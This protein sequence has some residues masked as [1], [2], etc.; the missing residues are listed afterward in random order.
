MSK[1]IDYQLK[2]VEDD[3]V[4][5]NNSKV[6]S[7]AAFK[8]ARSSYI[9]MGHKALAEMTVYKDKERDALQAEIAELREQLE[10]ARID[11]KNLKAE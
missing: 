9:G 1:Q 5:A 2:A 10:E 3:A 11:N 6:L 4:A 7:A 8:L